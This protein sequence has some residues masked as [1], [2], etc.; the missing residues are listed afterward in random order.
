[1]VGKETAFPA[2]LIS[3]FQRQT[4]PLRNFLPQ[5]GPDKLMRAVDDGAHSLVPLPL[6]PLLA[7]TCASLE[8]T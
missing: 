8:V 6:L 7:A 1:M 5:E 2:K 3:S 4:E